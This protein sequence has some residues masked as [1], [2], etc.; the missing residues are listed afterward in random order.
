MK[1]SKGK[2]RDSPIVSKVKAVRETVRHT[3]RALACIDCSIPIPVGLRPCGTGSLYRR[4][5]SVVVVVLQIM[6]GND[7]KRQIVVKDE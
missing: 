7:G 3:R 6:K 4:A 5:P 2:V 1:S